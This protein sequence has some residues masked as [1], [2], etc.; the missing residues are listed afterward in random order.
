MEG[1]ALS[2]LFIKVPALLF[3]LSLSLEIELI[4]KKFF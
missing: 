1:R 3:S 2:D 4:K